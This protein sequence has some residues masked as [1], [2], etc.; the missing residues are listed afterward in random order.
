MVLLLDCNSDMLR[1]CEGK[2]VLFENSI[3]FPTAGDLLKLP[4]SLYMCAS[5]S[6]LPFDIST[7][8]A[9]G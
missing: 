3:K 9:A 1:I 5:I 8:A 4:N 7:M 6:E 2:T